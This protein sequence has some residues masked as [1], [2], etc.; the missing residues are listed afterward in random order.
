[1]LENTVQ[2]PRLSDQK[3]HSVS[4][5]LMEE[6]ELLFFPILLVEA[7]GTATLWVPDNQNND[8]QLAI[9]VSFSLGVGYTALYG[10]TMNNCG[11]ANVQW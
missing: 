7:W 2:I 8:N 9:S 4:V 6:P 1:M 10:R 3:P 5:F 11:K